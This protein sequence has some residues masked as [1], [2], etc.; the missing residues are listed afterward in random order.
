MK[1]IFAPIQPRDRKPEVVNLQD[2]LLAL[3]DNK[4]FRVYEAPN[5][6][7][8][9]QLDE[10]TIRLRGEREQSFVGEATQLLVFIFQ[11]QQSL[12]DHLREKGVEET[13]AARLNE[14]LQ[15]LGLLDNPEPSEFVVRG[16]VTGAS[17][18]YFVRA[19]DKDFRSEE[20][21]GDSPL[22]ANHN[23]EIGYSRDKFKRAEKATADLRVAVFE[24]SGRELVSS[25]IYYNASAEITIDLTAG[26]EPAL[27][28][29]YERYVTELEGIMQGVTFIDI[30]RQEAAQREQDLDFL[31]GDTG[32]DRQHIAWLVQAAKFE[33]ESGLWTEPNIPAEIFYGLFRQDGPADWDALRQSRI[34]VLRKALLD[35]LDQNII[36]ARFRPQIEDILAQIPNPQ[37]QALTSVLDGANLSQTELRAVLAQVDTLDAVSDHA[38]S[39]LVGQQLIDEQKAQRIGLNVSLYRLSGGDASIVSTL[40]DEHRFEHARDIAALGPQD[41]GNVLKKAGSASPAG[42]SRGEYARSLALAAVSEFPQTGFAQRATRV[43]S[44]MEAHLEQMRPLLEKN[45]EALIL[46]FAQLDLDGMSSTERESLREAHTEL[47]RIANMHPGLGLYE[48][49]STPGSGVE[50]VAERIGWL[51]TVFE[52]NPEKSFLA[53]DYLPDSADI[54]T[55]DFGPLSEEARRAVLA[56]LK[57]HKRAYS[58][59]DNA[60]SAVEIIQA[61]FHSASGIAMMTVPDFAEVTGLVE[62]EARIYHEVALELGNTAV[63]Q[64]FKV[65]ELLRDK[66]MGPVRAIPSTGQ[67]FKPLEG[68]ADLIKD[69]TWCNC[70]HCQSVLSPAAYFVDLMGYIEKNIL[71]RSFRN[72]ESHPLH[73]QVRRPDLWDLDLTCSN[74]N[75]YVPYLDI[76][77]E[78][79]ERYI[80]ELLPH[81]VGAT[82]NKFLYKHLAEQERSFQQ[83]FT[84]PIERLEILLG[85]FGL[86]RYE[87]ARTM[88]SAR[89][90]QAR[91]RLK[92]SQKEYDLITS[93]RTTTGDL[94]FFEQLFRLKKGAIT[95]A[96]ADTV[97]PPLEMQTLMRA[98]NLAHDLLAAVLKSAFVNTDGSTTAR[99][100]IITGKRDPQDLQNN[101]KLVKQ[102]TLRR[103]DRIHRFA[104]LWRKLPWTIQELD[105]V[106]T[107]LSAPDLVSRIGAYQQ[108]PPEKLG[109]LEKILDLLD[110]NATWE[111]PV[112]ELMALTDVFPPQGLRDAASLFDRLFNPLPFVNQD[113]RWTDTVSIRFIHPAWNQDAPLGSSKPQNNTLTRLLAGLQIADKALLELIESLT[114]VP[115]IGYQAATA[116]ASKSILL[117]KASI[118]I[119]YHHARLMDLLKRPVA[120]FVKLIRLTP[121]LLR[122]ASEQY[123][124]DLDDVSAVVAFEA[125]QRASGFTLDEIIYVT[126]GARPEEA[127]KPEALAAQIV[128]R[129]KADKSLEF[130]DTV[131]TRIGLTDL[132]SRQ[133]VLANLNSAASAF[134][135]TPDG[136]AYHL[137]AGFDPVPG[138]VI[139]VAASIKPIIEPQVDDQAV[140]NLLRQYHPMSVLDVMLGG[141]LNRPPDETRLL[142]EL[143]HPLTDAAAKAIAVGLQTGNAA[144]LT[145]L[146]TDTLRFGV[147]FKSIVFNVVSLGFVLGHKDI[148]FEPAANPANPAQV[149][150][151]VVAYVALAQSTDE[152]F[153]LA[154]GPADI[155]ALHTV[156]AGPATAS[157]ED[158]AKV[159]RTDAARIGALKPHLV[160]LPV[161]PFEALNVLARCLALTEKLGV[162]GETL[163]LMVQEAATLPATFDQLSRAAEDIFGAFRARYPEEKTFQEKIEPFEDKLRA[164]KRDGLVDFIVSKWPAPFTDANKLYEYFLIDVLLEGC[165]RTSRIVAAISSLQLYVHRVLMNLEWSSDWDGNPAHGGVYARFD[166][167]DRQAEWYWR[168]HYRVW[169][170]NRKIFLYPE[171]YIEPALR[172]DKTPLF[173]DLEDTLLQ[174]EIGDS[175][176]HDAYGKYLTGFDEVARLKIAGVYYD[177]GPDI[178]HLLG[179]THETPTVYYYRVA[180]KTRTAK[181][182]LSAWQKLTLQIPAQKVSPIM[183]E[184]RLY[185]FWLEVT[186]HAVNSFKGGTSEFSGYRHTLRVRYTMLRAD[187]TWTAAQNLSFLENGAVEA[188]RVVDDPLT[189]SAPDLPGKIA[190]AQARKDELQRIIDNVKIQVDAATRALSDANAAL[191][192]PLT[193][194]ELATAA[195]VATQVGAVMAAAFLGGMFAGP[196]VAGILSANAGL[197]VLVAF[198]PGSSVDSLGDAGVSPTDAFQIAARKFAVSQARMAL[199]AI[200]GIYNSIASQLSQ[201]SAELARLK[202]LPQNILT[203]RWDPSGRDHSQP[204]ENYKPEGWKWDRVYPDVYTP[205][206]S[207]QEQR[208]RLMVVPSNDGNNTPHEIDFYAGVLRLSTERWQRNMEIL[209]RAN[210]PDGSSQLTYGVQWNYGGT[211]FYDETGYLNYSYPRS[212]VIAKLPPN[213]DAQIVNGVIASVIV[214]AKGDV[215]WLR[216]PTAGEQYLGTR[217]GTLLTPTLI[218]YFSHYGVRSLLPAEVQGALD[219]LKQPASVTGSAGQSK[220][221]IPR[222][223]F[224]EANAFQ[225][226]FRET[227]FHIPS[228]VANHLNSQLKFAEAQRWYHYI[229]NPTASDGLAWRYREFRDPYKINQSLYQMLTDEN[230][231]AVYRSDPF[232]PHAI[233]RTRLSAYQKSIVMKYIDNLLDWGD[234][235]FAQFTMESINEATMLYVMAQDILGPKPTVPG[236]CGEASFSPKTYRTIQSRRRPGE[237]ND[238]LVELE[239]PLMSSKRPIAWL[240]DE[241]GRRI[242]EMITVI[243]TSQMAST[244]AISAPPTETGMPFAR[245]FMAAAPG[246]PGV[247]MPPDERMPNQTGANYTPGADYAPNTG[248]WTSTGGTPLQD[249]YRPST[250]GDGFPIT[251]TDTGTPRLPANVTGNIDFMP[252]GIKP[253]GDIGVPGGGKIRPFGEIEPVDIQYGRRE[254]FDIE[255]PNG[256]VTPDKKLPAP[257]LIELVPPGELAFCIPSNKDLLAY[258]GR[259]EDRLFKIRNCMDIA[260]VR[261][262]LELFAPEID[263]R[264]L[265][266]MKAAGLTLEDVLNAT[267]GNVPPY[268]FTYLIEKARQYAGTLQNFGSALLSALEKRDSEELAQLR[269][270]HEHNVLKMRSRMMQMEIDAAEDT[271]E[272]LRRQKQTAQYRQTYFTALST[273]G[274]LPSES[275]QQQLQR[276]ASQYRTLAGLAQVLASVLTVIPDVGALTAMKFGGSQLGAAGRAVAE[277][278]NAVASFNEMGASMAG[279]EASNR[280]RDQEW[281][282]QI[283][284]AKQDVAGLEKQIE[285]AEI[286]RDMALHSFE[287]HEKTIEQ[288]QEIFD[289]MRDKF[290][291]FGRYTYLSNQLHLLYRQAFNATLGMVRMTE[292]AYR[293]ERTDDS[294]PLDGNY[295]DAGN[296]GLLAGERLLIDLQML[297]QQYIATNYRQLEI[298]QSFS[299]AQFAPD[300]L[301]NLRLNKTCAFNIPEWFFDLTYPGQYR[302]RLK[303]VRLTIPAVTGPY[304]NVGAT[305]RLDSSQIRLTVP[306]PLD[307]E[308]PELVSVPLRHTVAIAAS[309]AQYDA[310]VFDF[311]FRDERFMPFEGAGAV[312]AWTLSLPKTVRAFDYSTISDVIVHLSYTA[313]YDEKLKD[314]REEKTAGIISEIKKQTLTRVF[315]LRHDFPDV[316]HRLTT[317]ARDTR[318]NFSIEPRHFLFFLMDRPFKASHAN[319]RI[320]STLSSVEGATLAIGQKVASSETVAFR[321]VTAAKPATNESHGQG[322]SAFDLGDVLQNLATPMGIAPTLHGDYVIKLVSPGLL[323]HNPPGSGIGAINGT[324]LHDILL[325]IEYSLA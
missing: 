148:F 21:L 313:A 1:P 120:D 17:D 321:S 183:F 64:W 141:A 240:E 234:Q 220:I 139:T 186:T 306:Q 66:A 67:F 161:N 68:F 202:A 134:E 209:V 237:A 147:L 126:G 200:T 160:A 93:E 28:S 266:R 32:I 137:K 319:L 287:V 108:G 323:A 229:F 12:G 298:E 255:H 143:A 258:W 198:V 65:Y 94:P 290:S 62:A 7:T 61:G 103:L 58:V 24:P 212:T 196:V 195:V 251:G 85:H 43:P 60:I 8:Q 270:V 314:N 92:L 303:A 254:F 121:R 171:N 123:L 165:T 185:I 259:V 20:P 144:S 276:E 284:L 174:Q 77:N 233:A 268:R 288:S 30:D 53:L 56:D 138:S 38:L 208:I 97:F 260:G 79:L 112:D 153:T 296:A 203:A 176:V 101:T 80:W 293:A 309:K 207:L 221:T 107:R 179:V 168:E 90:I 190:S 250:D 299:L 149:I 87:V 16:H 173:K 206:N 95:I 204:L 191:K 9:E 167:L 264:L 249:L 322:V 114:E 100:D 305:L 315:S 272:G 244:A 3:L 29:E 122:P 283:Q 159:L 152:S 210:Q 89:T 308:L 131:F 252:G 320:L 25:E 318:V 247:G 273:I 256:I 140:T 98:T 128:A 304:T 78:I 278:L 292:Q 70:E 166:D 242:T 22:D 317:S 301:V 219:E 59:T 188:H 192:V 275:R 71:S 31:S 215:F 246:A 214:E 26:P 184:E 243:T 117:T 297:E 155:Q 115:A 142:R 132:Q 14:I 216:E 133:I 158:Y 5:S 57:V 74:T 199:Q 109:T 105:Y 45:K 164:R 302:R 49:F 33:Q 316:F 88:G 76:V 217:L 307:P 205:S 279:V 177:S 261:R 312:S 286:R 116:A 282:H 146:L 119:L 262:R 269:S 125:W 211:N 218:G 151:N 111:L 40:L 75:D 289:F 34:A 118:T 69:Q 129:V 136:T 228:L 48:V 232:N 106:L 13:T 225:T 291:N 18:G 96:S 52:R 84:L 50:V 19:Y 300:E 271:L 41:W 55:I 86:S 325:E 15:K 180:K 235:L 294:T 145:D 81:P 169:E 224:D 6:P 175:A 4:I 239:A 226:Y 27:P 181:P 245:S 182:R 157:E 253:A 83:P 265:V 72:R 154:S 63:L 280:R 163:S 222:D 162:S 127:L 295:W 238:F 236:P 231:L 213:S 230:A 42:M 150:R 189:A 23:Y 193:P 311:N 277:G 274:L 197:L 36:A 281:K 170:A 110:L 46:D 99:V 73:L 257:N 310:G 156:L 130:A 324:K 201:A 172:D 194:Q 124:R 82:L 2:A 187:G 10:L 37:T 35:A 91:A 104:R 51:Q 39:E 178:L 263:P 44:G 54:Q 285:A 102:L 227:F 135:L 11:V 267:S 47:K 223:P 113:D 248:Y 241:S